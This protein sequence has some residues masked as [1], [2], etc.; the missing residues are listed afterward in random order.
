MAGPIPAANMPSIPTVEG[1]HFV[2]DV[3]TLEELRR[4][5]HPRLAPPRT[6]VKLSLAGLSD[7]ERQL[8]ER[9]LGAQL[10]ACGCNEGS[11]ALLLYLAVAIPLAIWGPLAPLSGWGWAALVVGTVVAMIA[12]KV[13][14]LVVADLRLRRISTEIERRLKLGG[15]R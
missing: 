5:P 11:V 3:D 6:K 15:A 9:R 8:Y 4:L 13:L 1:A 14:G 7:D 10:A 12:G 2:I